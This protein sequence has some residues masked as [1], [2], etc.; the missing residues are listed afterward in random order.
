MLK[1]DGYFVCNAHKIVTYKLL[2]KFATAAMFSIGCRTWLTMTAFVGCTSRKMTTASSLRTLVSTWY[3]SGSEF[4]TSCEPAITMTLSNPILFHASAVNGSRKM[5]RRHSAFPAEVVENTAYLR[6]GSIFPSIIGVLV[7]SN[8]HRTSSLVSAICSRG[9]GT[10]FSLDVAS[11][12]NNV[13]TK[14]NP[15][16]AAMKT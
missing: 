7:V 12:T 4:Q 16:I 11:K 6:V 15:A 14:T 5:K 1:L 10:A 13:A 8:G 2:L 3:S 9:Q